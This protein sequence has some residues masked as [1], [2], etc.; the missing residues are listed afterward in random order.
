MRAKASRAPSAEQVE[1]E[2]AP[3]ESHMA[4]TSSGRLSVLLVATFIVHL[5]NGFSSIKL[6]RRQDALRATRL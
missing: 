1:A 2:A 3:K 6:H 4:F 5:P